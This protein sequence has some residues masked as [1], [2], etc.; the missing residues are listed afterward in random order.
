MSDK[1]KF[2]RT[3]FGRLAGDMVRRYYTHDVA[4]DSAALTYYLLFAIF[5][6]LIFI[7]TLLGLFPDK[8]L[9]VYQALRYF[10]VYDFGFTVKGALEILP[11]LYIVLT[12]ALVPIMYRRFR[13]RPVR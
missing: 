1:K 8:L 2:P 10:Y 6:L 4:R 13:K 7:S 3:G 12:A 11:V 5:P 9:E